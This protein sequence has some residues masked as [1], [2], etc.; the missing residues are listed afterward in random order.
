MVKIRNKVP[1]QLTLP[2]ILDRL[3]VSNHLVSPVH[4]DAGVRTNTVYICQYC[5][6][7]D[8]RYLIPSCLIS[9]NV[10]LTF[11]KNIHSV[12]CREQLFI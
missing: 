2:Y 7:Y 3:S 1:E 5:Q 11:F 9:L 10:S 4:F 12:I 6:R 8:G